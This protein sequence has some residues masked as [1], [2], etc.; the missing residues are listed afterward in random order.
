MIFLIAFCIFFIKFLEQKK[1]RKYKFFAGLFLG[2]LFYSTVYW[3]LY[4]W[5]SVAL[6][7]IYYVLRVRK[8]LKEIIE[9]IVIGMI[10]GI[11]AIVFNYW[12]LG[13]LQDGIKRAAMLIEVQDS[14]SL[15]VL[16][17]GYI[18]FF[19]ISFTAF[20]IARNFSEK[21]VFLLISAFCGIILL[22]VE[23]LTGIYLQMAHHIWFMLKFFNRIVIGFFL[24]KVED[25]SKVLAVILVFIMFVGFLISWSKFFVDKRNSYHNQDLSK[26][27]QWINRSTDKKDVIV[28]EDISS[29]GYAQTEIILSLTGRYVFHVYANYFSDLKDWEVFERFILK[30]KLLSSDISEISK[31]NCSCLGLW[32]MAA[33]FG[34]PKG[35]NISDFSSA[36]SYF[37]YI[38]EEAEKFLPNERYIK[39]LMQKYR[40]DYVIR[41]KPKNQSETYLHP[42]TQIGDFYIYKFQFQE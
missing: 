36:D 33:C 34:L 25:Y 11:P 31:K 26:I 20:L 28:M 39:S 42:I 10:V 1:N 16:P 19:I 3:W 9:V 37:R 15:L 30:E 17:R 2:F 14:L 12:Q 29:S 35:L 6:F 40:I 7:L 13:I 22:F 18:I 41:R 24:E 27:L 23:P 38:I 32:D 5:L 4:V 21:G 8:D